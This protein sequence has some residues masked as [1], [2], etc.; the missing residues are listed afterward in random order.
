MRAHRRV[1]PFEGG[2][3]DAAA[4]AAGETAACTSLQ[5][6][7]M[8]SVK[9]GLLVVCVL[10][11]SWVGCGGEEML[12][13]EVDASN[14]LVTARQGLGNSCNNIDITITNSRERNGVGTAIKVDRVE[15]WSASE[16]NWLPEDLLDSSISFGAGLTWLNEDLAQA[17]NDLLTKWR[18]YYRYKEADGDWSDPVYQEIDTTDDICR[19]DDNYHLTVQ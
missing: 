8:N 11:V 12:P 19:A 13:E 5:E 3:H 1:D 4:L 2:V 9:S 15:A 6:V 18:V 17:E 7:I 10:A 14:Q 16:G